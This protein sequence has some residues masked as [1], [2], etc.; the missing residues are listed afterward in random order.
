MAH[1]TRRTLLV[2]LSILV[3][4]IVG[5]LVLRPDATG[6]SSFA[7]AGMGPSTT[8]DG[9]LD[10]AD[11]FLADGQRLSVFDEGTPAL[12]NLDPALLGALRGAALDAGDDGVALLVNSGWR[13]SELQQHLLDEAV[14]EH[15]SREEAARWVATP[16]TSAHVSGD[17]VDVGPH[18]AAA[19]LAQ[20][21]AVHGLCRV[22]ANEP[23]HYE[24]RPDAMSVGC[25]PPY[26]DPTQDPRMQP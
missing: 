11:G 26:A 2:A 12:A 10:E 18:E 13:S 25:P 9:R 5:L 20:H 21:G 17:A 1:S 23:W 8:A 15:G 19:W 7:W 16:D 4:T 24:L 3:V 22:Y 6:S 14:V